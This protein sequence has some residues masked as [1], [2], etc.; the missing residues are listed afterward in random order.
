MNMLLVSGSIKPVE[1]K[2]S[3]ALAKAGGPKTTVGLA[4]RPLH[5]GVVQTK[6]KLLFA[7]SSAM[8]ISS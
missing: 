3:S 5:Y 4:E 8:L 6:F 2:I 1:K 7:A